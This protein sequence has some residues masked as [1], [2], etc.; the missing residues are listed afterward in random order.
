LEVFATQTNA[1]LQERLERRREVVPSF[2]TLMTLL[3]VVTSLAKYCAIFLLSRKISTKLHRKLI[4]NIVR[5][6]MTFFHT[7]LIGNILNRLSEDLV[8]I[9][10][11]VP[12]V[13]NNLFQVIFPNSIKPI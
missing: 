3:E 11:V 1:T 13:I 5:A 6:P 12:L 8:T 2:Y 4:T 9:D 7:N 10:E